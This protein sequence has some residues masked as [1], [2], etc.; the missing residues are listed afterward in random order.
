MFKLSLAN[1]DWGTWQ[2]GV[3]AVAKNLN[4]IVVVCVLQLADLIE[5]ENMVIVNKKWVIKV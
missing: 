4:S 5:S 3:N 2:N 1:K